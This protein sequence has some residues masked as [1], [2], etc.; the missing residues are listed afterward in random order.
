MALQ[1]NEEIKINGGI[2]IPSF[3]IVLE[4]KD[5]LVKGDACAELIHYVSKEMKDAGESPIKVNSV[6]K[7][8]YVR[9]DDGVDL[10]QIAHEKVKAFLTTSQGYDNEGE[11]LDPVYSSEDV[12]IVD[13]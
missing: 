8:E 7:F 10:L 12:T 3:Y 13:L 6:I 1:I 4:P 11:P 2:T 5:L 9:E